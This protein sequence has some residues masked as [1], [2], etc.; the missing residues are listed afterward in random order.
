[1]SS[2][3][4]QRLK[5]SRPIE[6][7]TLELGIP[8]ALDLAQPDVHVHDQNAFAVLSRD[9]A[10]AQPV[11]AD[12]WAGSPYSWLKKLP[13]ARRANAARGLLMRWLTHCGIENSPV[14]QGLTD[15]G[16]AD[17]LVGPDAHP[18]KVKVSTVWDG[19]EFVFQQLRTG[20]WRTLALLGIAPHRVHL[21]AVPT[22]V[23]LTHVNNLGWLVVPAGQTPAWLAPYG[24]GPAAGAAVL[25]EVEAGPTLPTCAFPP[26]IT[27]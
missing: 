4:R 24:G 15:G 12:P 8:A 17:L 14:T 19:G 7:L 11:P 13:P 21:W 23:A 16:T 18:V 20:P 27:G 9:I 25:N 1:M 5:R 10:A 3:A 22:Q 2:A 6:Q 26:A